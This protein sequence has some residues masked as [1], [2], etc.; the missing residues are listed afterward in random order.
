MTRKRFTK[1]FYA[2]MQEIHKKNIE[3]CGTPSKGW[4]KVLDHALTTKPYKVDGFTSYEELWERMLPIRKV[5]G[6]DKN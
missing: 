5:Y 3:V 4:G 2:L 1:L 6:M